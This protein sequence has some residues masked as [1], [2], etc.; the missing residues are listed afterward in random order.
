MQIFFSFSFNGCNRNNSLHKLFSFFPTSNFLW[1]HAWPNWLFLYVLQKL[2]FSPRI[3]DLTFIADLFSE[4]VYLFS[5]FFS[6]GKKDAGTVHTS[7]VGQGWVAP[8]AGSL[9][10]HPGAEP[11][12]CF[13]GCRAEHILPQVL[14]VDPS[15]EPL[16]CL[17]AGPLVVN[18]DTNHPRVQ[19]LLA[20]QV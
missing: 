13:H 16:D 15:A 17:S 11:L 14:P 10:I 7:A 20:R 8:Y 1:R 5:I 9:E 18:R 2:I 3:F 6:L 12:R 19:Y 4:F